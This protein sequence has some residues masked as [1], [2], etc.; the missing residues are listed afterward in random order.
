MLD[1]QVVFTLAIGGV[2]FN[3]QQDVKLSLQVLY[4]KNSFFRL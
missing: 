2:Y 3:V 1:I 4:L